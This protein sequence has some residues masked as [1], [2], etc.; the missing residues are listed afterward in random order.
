MVKT[1]ISG[2]LTA[3]FMSSAIV[4]AQPTVY[5]TDSKHDFMNH[6]YDYI[7]NLDVFELNQEEGRAYY[8]PQHHKL[9]NGQW[10]FFFANTP[11]GIPTNFFE[12]G[13]ADKKWQNIDVP[14]NWEMRGFGDALFR[15]VQAPFKANPPYVPHDYNPTGAYRTTFTVP[16]EWSGEEVFLRFE[17]VASASFLWVN[18]HEVG[19]NEG[20]QEPA[21]YNITPFLK[22]GKNQLSML[23]IKYSDGYYLEGQDYWRLAGIFDDVYLYASP[24]TRLFDW[25]VVTDLD[26]NYCDADLNISA[27]IRRY[28]GATLTKGLYVK[29]QLLDADGKEVT[30]FNS[31][32]KDISGET[33][34]LELKKHITNPLKWTA[35]TPYLYT[36]NLSLLD[37]DDMVIDHAKQDVGFKK[38]EMI[39]NVFYLNGKKIKVNAQC[40]HMQDPDN[41]HCVTDELIKKDMTILKQFGFNAVRTS[42]YPPVPRYLQYAARYGLYIIDE[43][44]VEAHATEYVSSDKR[45]IPMYQE[46][47]RRMVLRDRNQPAVLFWSAGNESGEGPN[48]GEVIREGRKYDDTRWWMYG[49]NAY[50]HPD[51][52]IIGPRYPTPLA[53][54]LKVG[55]HHDGDSRP[56]FMDEYISVAGN[57]GGFFDEMWRAIYQYDRTMGGAVWDFVSPGL[58]ATERRLKDSSPLQTMTHLMGNALLTTS[59]PR[60][61]KPSTVLDLNGH[62]QWV[63]VYRS[64]ELDLTDDALTIAFDVFPRQLVSSCGSFVTKGSWQFGVQQVG[65]DKLSFYIHTDRTLGSPRA[66]DNKYTVEGSLPD[67]WEWNWHHVVAQYDGKKMTLCIDNKLVAETEAIGR[68]VNAPFPVNIGRNAEIHGQDTN[69]HICDAQLDNVG[70]F[71]SALSETEQTA[72]NALLYLDFEE[73][74]AGNKYFSYGIGARTY[75]T[76]WPDRTIQPEIWQMKK[77]TQ[78]IVCSLVNADNRTVEVWNRSAFLN[79]NHY[80][81]S[82]A[83]YEDGEMIENGVLPLNIEPQTRSIIQVP[84]SRPQIKTNKEY[85]LMI[86]SRL[87]N[88]EL[89][90]KSGHEVAWDQIELPWKI[91]EKASDN[92]VGKIQLIQDKESIRVI[93]EGFV[94]TFDSDGQLQSMLVGGEEMLH[95]PLRLNIWRA[96]VAPE[97]DGW[98]SWNIPYTRRDDWN[99]NQIANEWFSNHLDNTTLIPI[100]CR[101]YESDGQAYIEVRCFTQYGEIEN[102]ALDAYIFGTRYKGMEEVYNFRINGDGSIHLHHIISPESTQ[103]SLLGRIGLTMTLN[104][105]MQQVS[106]YG[107]GPEENYPDRKSGYPIG[108]YNTTVDDMYEP[109]LIPQDHGLRCDNRWVS[110]LNKDG[111]GIKISMNEH[112]NFNAYPFSTDNLTRAVYQYQLQRQDGITL[113]LDYATTGVGCT[114]CYVLPGYQAKAQ[115]YERD[116]DIQLIGRTDLRLSK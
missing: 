100:A 104:A 59:K 94:Y 47:V 57:S 58:T 101:A 80:Y 51:E 53:L 116:I 20:A 27:T 52:E 56:S 35:E 73:E 74:Y 110:F 5:K 49:G 68:L 97:V 44:G 1:S 81:T 105:D 95:E 19:Y 114:A 30:S 65:K 77:S 112:F 99:G 36:L 31:S 43:A 28:E 78:P 85:R 54:D 38:T 107:R 69:V 64:K 11:E 108:V 109:Y 21:E 67:D 113:N 13:F 48:I 14:S 40:S 37:A 61:K 23:V 33:L 29:A 84:F 71:G 106:Y 87:K 7:E 26:N 76:I 88:D 102:R 34:N 72:D 82:W 12:E 79:T 41:G 103:P 75:G 22:K 18:G 115:R 98:G 86:S 39:D 2:L 90:A 45:F 89:W 24:K 10:K 32:I 63:E 70:I 83:L 6:I 92:A 66:K 15:N 93:G 3:F 46:R 25:H 9:L 8:I 111:R 42:H 16:A 62:D 60:G 17:K 96:P 55:H 91:T 4:S 50:S